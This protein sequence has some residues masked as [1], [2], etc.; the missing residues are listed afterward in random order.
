MIVCLFDYHYNSQ[1][2]TI[3]FERMNLPRQNLI[4]KVIPK[5][6]GEGKGD[7]IQTFE[8]SKNPHIPPR[9][10]NMWMWTV[11]VTPV[12]INEELQGAL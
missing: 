12:T 11:D 5:I 3:I 9:M 2:F 8:N 4:R 1:N 10:W 6:L 7:V